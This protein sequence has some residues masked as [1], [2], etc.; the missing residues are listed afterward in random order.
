MAIDLAA[1]KIALETDM[2]YDV[3]VRSGICPY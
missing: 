3:A 1:L 2:R